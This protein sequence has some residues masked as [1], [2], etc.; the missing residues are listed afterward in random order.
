MDTLTETFQQIPVHLRQTARLLLPLGLLTGAA[1]VVVNLLLHGRPHVFR[2]LVTLFLAT[3]SALP[4]GT[5]LAKSHPSPQ[6][7]I[8]TA[9]LFAGT[10]VLLWLFLLRSDALKP[11][12]EVGDR[13]LF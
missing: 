4:P 13:Y 9:M 1:F 6:H 10:A 5:L 7:Q 3:L 8:A 2:V 11:T 12:A